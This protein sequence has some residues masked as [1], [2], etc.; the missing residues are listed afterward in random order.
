MHGHVLQHA[1]PT[2]PVWQLLSNSR[3]F[4]LPF[5]MFQ[6]ADPGQPTSVIRALGSFLHYVVVRLL[7]WPLDESSL[8]LFVVIIGW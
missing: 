3:G 4:V 8:L 6:R 5:K 1:K 7:L 2:A